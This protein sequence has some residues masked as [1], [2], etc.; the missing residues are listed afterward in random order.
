[1]QLTMGLKHQMKEKLYDC[2][3]NRPKDV[4]APDRKA[5]ETSYIFVK[6][7]DTPGGLYVADAKR[8]AP[9]LGQK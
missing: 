1:M 5:Q 7:D 8:N 2:K 9:P 4:V 6:S 3:K